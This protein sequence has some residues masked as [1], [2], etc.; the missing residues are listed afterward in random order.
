MIRSGDE[1]SSADALMGAIEMV[2]GTPYERVAWATSDLDGRL[3][4]SRVHLRRR[5]EV[6][7][8]C[9]T[10]AGEGASMRDVSTENV[11]CKSCLNRLVPTN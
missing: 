3:R 10:R 7:A 6:Q 5:G 2:A 1:D 9:G 11:T 8:I 4:A